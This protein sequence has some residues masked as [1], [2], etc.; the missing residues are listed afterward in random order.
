MKK[1]L[2]FLS[3]KGIYLLIG[4]CLFLGLVSLYFRNAT[5]DDDLYLFETSIMT[6]ALSRGEWFGD[7][8][9]GTHGFLF[10]LPVALVFLLTGPSLAIATVWNVLLACF[11]L[12]LFYKILK[13]I[14]PKGIYPFLGTLL[15]FCNFQ[16][17]L[18]LPTYMREFPVIVGVLLLLYFLVNKKSY[19]L[20][21]LA[22][23]VIL[24]GKEY[25]L[26]MVAPALVIYVLIVKWK[27]FNL[28]TLWMYIKSYIQIFLPSI[29]FVLLMI[30]TSTVPLNMYALSVIPGVTKGGTQYQIDHFDVEKATTNRIED[31]APTLQRELTPEESIWKRVYN[32]VV[33]YVGKILY[34]RTFSFLSIPKVI[35]FPA[36]LTALILF[37]K[38][39]KEKKE[40][41]LV[42]S[43][44]L[45]SYIA[46][47]ILRASFDRY[48]FP[49][50]PVVIFFF[51][52]FLKD[53]VKKKKVFLMILGITGLLTFL[54]LFFEVDYILLKIILNLVLLATFLF[55]VF[56]YKKIA[57]L[58]ILIISL[59]AV[60][61]FSVAAYFFYANGQIRKYILWG[62]DYEV[63]AVVE[64]FEEDENI[65]INDPGWSLLSNVYRVD[66]SY[67]PEWK[68]ELE[69]WV[70]RK[71]KLKSF[72]RF[73]VYTPIGLSISND[74]RMV[75]AY[76]IE[77]VA[78]VISSLEGYEFPFTHK[79][80]RYL[81]ASWL[82]LEE[83]INLKNKDL[84]I[85]H[86][87][88]EKLSNI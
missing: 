40:T 67:N 48:I 70:P 4:V 20:V 85:F 56:F 41:H 60:I 34:P 12:F 18:N 81:D 29:I 77:T 15:M 62:R 24:E 11:S 36:F 27:G 57:N 65:M 76:D 35:M 83:I 78:L 37:K 53:I 54:G 50:L 82:E 63:E 51:L 23:L 75:R 1:L 22:A 38:Y 59:T 52:I 79:F 30:F 21:G 46:I 9:V 68:W 86:V 17:V 44:L 33:S 43:L 5:L 28:N 42:F 14:F 71:K 10:K 49:I 88:R 87:N 26:F 7:Y 66:N 72:K 74:V 73:S 84:Y 69:E 3:A 58:Y 39:L 31:E 19:W 61:T 16:F 13:E 6:E 47:F 8:A 2:T 25:V 64:Y 45:F 32:T 80:E 55:Y